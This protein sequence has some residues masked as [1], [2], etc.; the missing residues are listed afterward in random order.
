M[1]P[2]V[3]SAGPRDVEAHDHVLVAR[4]GEDDVL[5]VEDDV[6]DVLG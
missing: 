3:M 4:A 2:A 6:G 1:S 5:D